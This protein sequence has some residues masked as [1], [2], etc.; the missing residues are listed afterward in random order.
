MKRFAIGADIGGSHI[1]CALV[2][3]FEGHILAES[4]TE[5]DIDNKANADVILN[6]WTEALQGTISR[7]G[8]DNVAGVGFAMPGP[9]VYDKGIAMFDTSVAKF[10]KLYKVDV[11]SELAI[12]LGLDVPFCFMN[13]ASA[14][15]VGEAWLGEASDVKKSVSITL[16]T[17]FGSA[18]IENGVP[19]V[20]GVGV[21]PMGCVW[22]LPVMAGIADDYFSTRW[23][24]SR[25][26]ELSGE[27]V[28][29][30]KSIADKATT[31]EKALSIFTEFGTNMGNFLGPWLKDF[32]SDKLVIGGNVTGAYNLFGPA[33]ESVLKHLGVGTQIVL[34]GLKEDAAI[35]GS[36]RMID[37]EYFNL[38]KPVL[39]KM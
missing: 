10:E 15:A 17:G 9:F 34:S 23:Y 26:E 35:I 1:S 3:M 36:A 39:P 13:D 22:H 14:F 30:V 33:F 6:G 28:N 12:R 2:D 20:E 8:E 18:F 5:R 21:P 32:G 25:W 11:G 16:G 24:I 29:G 19:V 37:P 27:K 4:H 7:V 31:D 38:I